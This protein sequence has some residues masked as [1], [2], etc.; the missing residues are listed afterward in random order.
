MRANGNSAGAEPAKAKKYPIKHKRP[1]GQIIERG[2]K[3]FLVWLYSHR[4]GQGKPV[5]YTKTF[6]TLKEADKHLAEKVT[7]RNR[8]QVIFNTAQRLDNLIEWYLKEVH[9]PSVR[10]QSHA[11][12]KVFLNSYVV[13]HIGH[14]RVKDLRSSDLDVLYN[15]LREDG[16][17]TG[18]PLSNCSIRKIHVWLKCIFEDAVKRGVLSKNPVIG[19]S[20]GRVEHGEIHYF[21]A[22][23][24]AEFL[25]VWE[26]YQV[27]TCRHFA[28]HSLGPLWHFGFET[29]VRPEELM[30]LR[31]S[32]VS[33]Q[34][35][36]V[37]GYT[38]PACGYIRQVAVRNVRLKGWHFDEPKTAKSRRTITI[39]QALADA[40]AEHR[41]NVALMRRQAGAR[42]TEH[43]LVFPN[44]LGEPLYD[45]R[46]RKVFKSI[47]QEMGLDPVPYSLYSMRHT[48]ATLLLAR[49]VNPKV[50][51]E[52]LGHSTVKV[53]LDTYSHVM[54]SL[55][56]EATDII[57]EAIFGSTM[58]TDTQA[59]AGPILCEESSSAPS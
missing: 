26:R 36:A 9:A 20:P 57:H 40:L 32:D 4:D 43:G 24:V 5:R 53:T 38:V 50:V 35:T 23:Q 10:P 17:G 31:W 1:V 14:R 54:P 21:T 22:E 15:R 47:V 29:G 52:R 51:Q 48:M 30:G 42:W 33:L 18:R 28:K 11:T 39:S 44:T 59:V 3:Q 34:P 7:E 49:N 46:L 27:E 12:T 37:K 2:P 8:G 45:Y 58:S 13:P 41:P 55:Q 6:Q 56:V 25:A 19:A 16:A